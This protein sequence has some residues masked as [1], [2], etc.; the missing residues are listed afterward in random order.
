M[1]KTKLPA[2]LLL[3]VFVLSARS[4]G[5][6]LLLNGDFQIGVPQDD[7]PA[8][9]ECKWWR[10]ELW[11]DDAW[12]SWLTDG[13]L[14][15]QVGAGNQALQYR[16]GATS[17]YQHFSA[18]A[19]GT[20]TFAVD[21]YNAGTADNR[22][23]P[24][25]Q[26]EWFDA[27]DARIG[28]T[29]T[30]AEADIP[31]DPVKTWT[32]LTGSAA[33]PAG[34]AYARVMLNVNNRGA[35]NYWQATFLDNAS[36]TGTPGT[37][38][39]P[40]SFISTPYDLTLE[41]IY[42]STPYNDT[43]T[44]YADDKD[45]DTLNFTVHAAP[46]WL[47][48]GTD[49]AMSGTPQFSDA[50]NN[51]ISVTV[52]DGHGHTDT[53]T[54]TL[55]VVGYLRTANLFDDD[56]VLQ[57]GTPVPVWGKAVSNA[58]V[59]VM[60]STGESA[61]TASDSAGDWSVTL[62]AMPATTNGPV[63]MTITSGP[64]T[65]QV[66]NLL[67]GDVWFCSGQ[68]NME[69]I[70]DS[71]DG[72]AAEIAA[73][74]YPNLR[75]VG[76]PQTSDTAPWEELDT[77][78]DW[79]VCHPDVVADF[80][81]VAYYFGKHLLL[82]QNI[83]I[84]LI[85]SAQGGTQI[86]KWAVNLASAGTDT[87]YNSRVHPYTRMPI[88]GAIWYQ[89]EA[90][91]SDGSAYT[92][93]M[94]TLVDD[95]RSVWAQ[96][97][98]PFYFVQLAPYDYGGDAVYNLPELW[99]AQT[100]AMLSISNSGMAVINDVGDIADIH[101]RNKAP[102]GERLALWARYGTYG[103]TNLVHMGPMVREVIRQDS[104]LRISFNHVGGGLTTRDGLSPD[105]FKVAGADQVYV[106]AT[107]VIDS[108]AVLVNAPSV[109]EPEWVRFAWHETA[110]P[111]L[112]NVEGLPATAFEQRL[113]RPR[114]FR[115][116]LLQNRDF[117]TGT[118]EGWMPA[119]FDVPF[120]ARDIGTYGD[121]RNTW[122]TDGS[123]YPIIGVSNRALI[124]R[125]ENTFAYQEFAAVAGEEY[126]FRV[127][128]MVDKLT[129]KW[130]PTL[131][132]EWLDSTNGLIGSTV[133]LDQFDFAVDPEDTWIELT[134]SAAAAG[135]AAA[136]RIVLCVKNAGTGSGG[137]GFFDNAS[138]IGALDGITY[139]NWTIENGI[140]ENPI[141]DGDSATLLEEYAFNLDPRAADGHV[142]LPGIG[143]NG[144]PYWEISTPEGLTVEYLRRTPPTDLTYTVQFSNDLL[145]GWVNASSTESVTPIN[146][147]WERVMVD[148]PV[149]IESATNRFGRVTVSTNQA[150]ADL[151][152][153]EILE[154]VQTWS[155]E[156]NY[157][158]TATVSVPSGSGPH[159][160]LIALHGAGGN[161]NF[162]NNYSYL[163]RMIRVG[164]QGYVNRWNVGN[165]PSLAPDVEFIREL[166]LQLRTY[167]NV[168]SGNIIILGS[169]NGAA[170]VN[171][172]LI[173]LEGGL[174]HQGIKLAG[175]LNTSQYHDSAFWHDP[176]GGNAYDT[177]TEPAGG[178]RILS[179][180]GTA[181]TT[182]PYAGG[183]G[184]AGYVFLHAQD[185]LYYWAEQMGY[186]GSQIPDASGVPVNTD[187]YSYS[188]LSGDVVMIKLVGANHGLQPFSSSA[189][190]RLEAVIKDFLGH[191]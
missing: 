35:G 143:T 55:P 64:R 66:T 134:G 156:T 47:T 123:V 68:S 48:I 42:E 5:A 149:L 7:R 100:A 148:D 33:A 71:T 93:K 169:S 124:N 175:Q 30:A 15:W 159:P 50:G 176:S 137:F 182:V 28:G 87:F 92:A 41:A 13:S 105:W 57:R 185:S 27:A 76:T 170:L 187:V 85:K 72:S 63:T 178:R 190:G 10:R 61:A 132:V 138:V 52:D 43:L 16:W 58:P 106:A 101:P 102:V 119:T 9:F 191:P 130:L 111:N 29:V 133:T 117:E 127:D 96:G 126:T 131:Q 11:A 86:E 95:W 177:S 144:L 168:D 20:Y 60:M 3:T 82:D 53:R 140:A 81:A 189:D 34:T 31:N 142:M 104:Q 166:I 84:G 69:W 80:S 113:V 151:A 125:W 90:N 45:G 40:C 98:F 154:V 38:N 56:M 83:P 12:N 147:N 121:I 103:Q 65:M 4:F 23:Q 164:P 77:R 108:D 94:E 2:F 157:T 88:T 44:N 172:L 59:S 74:D 107:A 26:V 181:D 115:G 136:G 24:R 37:G 14:D 8:S 32:T 89:G 186:T 161:S 17:I 118:V 67:V 39:L 114:P 70:L 174:F 180:V 158:R 73:A 120:W 160:V 1:R 163:D 173:E 21:F 165:E 145:A 49:G 184:V 116:E 167:G 183:P 139:E 155:Q 128:A 97:A 99:A 112:M 153:G 152:N 171:R 135:G 36:V 188:Y 146:A 91:I 18:A 162:A 46:A 179:V 79:Q 75:Y 141:D 25:I 109:P 19:G 6:E 62:P 22:W 110:E 54:L 150:Q 129:G 51:Q 78:A 122:L